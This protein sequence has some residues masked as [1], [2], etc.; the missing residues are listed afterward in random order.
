MGT[1]S[2]GMTQGGGL[3]GWMAPASVTVSRAVP[4]FRA[5]RVS[6]PCTASTDVS[7]EA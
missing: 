7:E 1:E 2:H 6:P 4:R 5:L 3:W